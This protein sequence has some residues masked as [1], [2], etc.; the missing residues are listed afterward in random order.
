MD[1]CSGFNPLHIC[2]TCQV[3]GVRSVLQNVVATDFLPQ[4]NYNVCTE[5]KAIVDDSY[6]VLANTHKKL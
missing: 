1:E 4:K 2:P 5:K 3:Y 6:Y